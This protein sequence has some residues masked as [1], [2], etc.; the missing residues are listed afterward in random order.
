MS[1]LELELRKIIEALSDRS[2]ITPPPETRDKINTFRILVKR[3][4]L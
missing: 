3:E 4:K 2:S 1:R